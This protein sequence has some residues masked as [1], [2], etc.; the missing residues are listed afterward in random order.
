MPVLIE[1]IKKL[2]E[3]LNKRGDGIIIEMK[4]ELAK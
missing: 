3:L 1:Q 2:I 4:K